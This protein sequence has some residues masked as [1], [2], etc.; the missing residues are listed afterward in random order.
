MEKQMK[1]ITIL[2]LILFVIVNLQAED[3]IADVK[4]NFPQLTEIRT[5]AWDPDSDSWSSSPK[6]RKTYSWNESGSM[7][8]YDEYSLTAEG[9][10][11]KIDH[12]RFLY[13]DEGRLVQ[14]IDYQKF[15]N[16]P[17][18]VFHLK[19][20]YTYTDAGYEEEFHIFR[21]NNNNSVWKGWMKGETARDSL[22][23]K[24]SHTAYYLD[25]TGKY[26]LY[27]YGN[28]F[29]YENNGN[30]KE[31]VNYTWSGGKVGWLQTGKTR[32]FYD[33]NEFEIRNEYYNQDPE[34]KIWRI[35][36]LSEFS[37]DT[38]GNRIEL[39]N[40]NWN[41][42]TKEW[43]RHFKISKAFNA[44]G[45]CAEEKY[46]VWDETGQSWTGSAW[47]VYTYADK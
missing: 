23:R 25:S 39:I 30:L 31:T 24:I 19:K 20:E 7:A 44:E 6:N 9:T 17:E 15:H 32:H 21:W 33:K 28:E 14:K 4:C 41:S 2:I 26:W 13:N 11:Q 3:L 12:C 8:L 46:Y 38:G 47:K 5:Y 16:N 43:I 1:K 34:K 45:I 36:T 29:L 42:G 22:G 40:F 10:E 18:W 27:N 37:Y 35:R